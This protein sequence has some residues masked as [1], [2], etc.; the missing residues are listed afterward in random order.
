MKPILFSTPMVKAILEGRKTQ[1]RRV[2]RSQ[3]VEVEE[4]LWLPDSKTAVLL[5]ERALR[6]ALSHAIK[7]PYQVGDV[8]WVR[9]TFMLV[10]EY[11]DLSDDGR[12][13][14]NPYISEEALAFWRRRIRYRADYGD[15]SHIKAHFGCGWRS[16]LF[17]P[18]WA[19]RLFL[20]VTA[21]RVERLQE[22]GY[23]DALAEGIQRTGAWYTWGNNDDWRTPEKAFAALWD[24]LNAKRGFGWDVNPWVVVVE[25]ERIDSGTAEQGVLM[26]AGRSGAGR[27]QEGFTRFGGNAKED[28]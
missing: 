26:Q 17:M 21:V 15:D 5:T 8:L 13:P 1:T 25:F 9:E 24:S 28:K 10:E 6:V 18:R 2:L 19:A 23:A 3:P 7:L 14:E 20:K 11:P 12:L 4:W 27:E 22:I 16:P